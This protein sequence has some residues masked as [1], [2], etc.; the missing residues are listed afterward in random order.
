MS[1]SADTPD[2]AE[3]TSGEIVF[4]EI[5]RLGLEMNILELEEKGYTIV[6]DALPLDMVE[7]MREVIIDQTTDKYGGERPDIESWDGGQLRE[8]SYLLYEDPVFEK[9]VLNEFT[10]ATDTY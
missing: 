6:P 1:E 7:C 8:G 10:V 4:A 3:L 9:L 2:V 5:R